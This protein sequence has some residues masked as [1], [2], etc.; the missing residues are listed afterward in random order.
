MANI[1]HQDVKVAPFFNLMFCILIKTIFELEMFTC[2][3]YLRTPNTLPHCLMLKIMLCET[4][5]IKR[6]LSIFQTNIL[7]FWTLQNAKTN[8]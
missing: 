1:S 7:K 4:I 5:L 3:V 6:L 2:N 8:K